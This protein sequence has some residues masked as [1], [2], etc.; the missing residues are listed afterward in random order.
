M[1]IRAQ[2]VVKTDNLTGFKRHFFKIS[3]INHSQW[4]RN[5]YN[6]FSVEYFV[7]KKTDSLNTIKHYQKMQE[8]EILWNVE[9]NSEIYLKFYYVNQ[10]F[11]DG[12]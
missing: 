8:S 7:N 5:R 11:E 10:S 12:Q 9:E 1:K 2:I 3:F 6:N 4:N